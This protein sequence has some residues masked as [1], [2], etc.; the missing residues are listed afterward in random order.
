LVSPYFKYNN[1]IIFINRAIGIGR[2]RMISAP[3]GL[4]RR[5]SVYGNKINFIIVF[6]TPSACG[7]E[8]GGAIIPPL[9]N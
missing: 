3:R 5:P 8:K 6:N 1:I 2:K 4:M 7:G 9:W